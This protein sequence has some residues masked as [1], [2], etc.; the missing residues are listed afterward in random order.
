MSE[1]RSK[2]D[3]PT[4]SAQTGAVEKVSDIRPGMLMER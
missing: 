4:E 3:R 2:W 1:R